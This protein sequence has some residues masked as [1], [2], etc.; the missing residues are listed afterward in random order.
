MSANSR[1]D[2]INR[3]ASPMKIVEENASKNALELANTNKEIAA[4]QNLRSRILSYV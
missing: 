2:F 3:C 4:V 1:D